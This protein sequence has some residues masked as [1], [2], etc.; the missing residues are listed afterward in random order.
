MDKQVQHRIRDYFE[1]RLA[2][3]EGPR[4]LGAPAERDALPRS[5]AVLCRRLPDH[6]QDQR[7]GYLHPDRPGSRVRRQRP[8]RTGSRSAARDRKDGAL[9]GVGETTSGVIA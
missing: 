2:E 9:C 3:T 4:Q 8:H 5:L 6:R 7:Q 1:L